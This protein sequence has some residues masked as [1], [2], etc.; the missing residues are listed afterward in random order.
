MADLCRRNGLSDLFPE[1]ACDAG[2]VG[3]L[4]AT[5]PRGQGP[6]LWVQD[7]V[8]AREAGVPYLTEVQSGVPLLRVQVGRAADVLQAME[9][10]LGCGA[11]AAVVGEIWGDPPALSFTATKRLALR[12][13]SNAL[14]CWLVRRAG[15]PNL[16]AARNRWRVTS[17]PSAAHPDDAKAPGVPRWHVDLFRSRQAKP[18]DWMVS[19]DRAAHRLDFSATSGDGALAEMGRAAGERAAG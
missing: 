6:V 8:S 18:G 16:S 11:L 2:A 1:T 12:A 9:D 14:P 13:D 10:G 7:R 17:A 15:A 19:Y 3:F 4:L 5:L